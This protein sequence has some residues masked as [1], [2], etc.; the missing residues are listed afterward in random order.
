MVL[1]DSIERCPWPYCQW[2]CKVLD[3]IELFE[4]SRIERVFEML[5]GE[6]EVQNG[7]ICDDW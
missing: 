1:G 2:V 6:S 3:G 4:G 5:E 7:G